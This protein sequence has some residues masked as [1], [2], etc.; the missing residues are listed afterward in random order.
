M[1]KFAY[2]LLAFALGVIALVALMVA[3][4]ERRLQKD[5]Q[6]DKR[7]ATAKTRPTIVKIE[8]S[9]DAPTIVHVAFG[10]DS[11]VL[12][13][14]WSFCPGSGLDC[15]FP[16][17]KRSSQDL[18]LGGKYLNATFSFDS[19]VT[20][21]VTKAEINV[22]N[23]GWYDT[24]DVSLV[25]GFSNKVFILAQGY[26]ARTPTL[27]GPPK[28]KTGNEKVFGLFP[29]GCDIC[30]ARQRP[31]CGIEKGRDGCKKGTQYAPDVLCQY[32]GP[33]KIG[34]QDVKIVLGDVEPA[35]GTPGDTAPPLDAALSK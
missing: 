31:P 34:G 1:P 24:L 16:L 11:I 19:T 5:K 30:V 14:D 10:S 27:L 21:N 15:T 18:P 13:G 17:A 4:P 3:A 12:P 25:D 35:L 32:Q 26:G 33:V 8:N 2:Y 28:G 9:T 6:E 22:N 23:P 7:Q 20:C 29:Y